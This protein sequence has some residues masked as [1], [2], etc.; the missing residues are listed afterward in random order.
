M[1]SHRFKKGDP[2]PANSG[3]KKGTP[4]KKKLKKVS[5]ALAEQ[6][7][8]LVAQILAE[9]PLLEDKDRMRAYFELLSYCEAKPKF[10]EEG[11]GDI[12]PEEFEDVSTENLLELVKGKS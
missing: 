1:A 3:R 7:L 8:D 6:G 9:I 10:T 11:P 2:K 5:E 4:N 12:D